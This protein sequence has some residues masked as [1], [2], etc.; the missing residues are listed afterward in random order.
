MQRDQKFL[1]RVHAQLIGTMKPE[2]PVRLATG[3][4]DDVVPHAQ[5]K[6]LAKAWCEK[7]ANI[8]YAPLANRSTGKKSILNH[9]GP[10]VADQGAARDWILDRFADKPVTSNCS[11]LSSMN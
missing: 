9:A 7:G 2:A 10:L 8:S 11:D 5:A 4:A 6:Q 1:D 3:I